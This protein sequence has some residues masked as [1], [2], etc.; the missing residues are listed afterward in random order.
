[1]KPR[2]AIAKDATAVSPRRADPIDTLYERHLGQVKR[3]ARQ[4][5]GPAVDLEDLVHDIFLVAFKKGF[6]D[7]GEG[8]VDTWLFRITH[9]EVRARRRRSRVRQLLLGQHQ[10]CLAPVAPNTPQQEME[11]QERRER[12]YR[13]LDRLPD[14]YRTT[15]IL[16]EIEELSGERVAEFTGISLGTVWVRLHRG[17]E[18]LLE[19]LAGDNLP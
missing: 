16:F 12:L 2:F 5:A 17:R 10:E 15:L 11:R 9:H 7:R 13:A 1:M 14:R 8:S 18:R 4:L 19:L 6:Q 3:W